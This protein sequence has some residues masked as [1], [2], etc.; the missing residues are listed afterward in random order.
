MNTKQV[1]NIGESSV[2][3]EFVYHNVPVYL[4]FGDNDVCDLIAD[5]GGKLQR[6]QV[7]TTSKIVNNRIQ[8]K[9]NSRRYD[10]DH[11][12]ST[13]EVDYF[14]LFC[15]ENRKTYLVKN[16]EELNCRAI[17]LTLNSSENNQRKNA[18]IS[19]DYEIKNV[20]FNL[21]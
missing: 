7:K 1:G 12:Y 3:S 9:L 10:H 16:T 19:D 8:F 15:V 17:T 4:P 13:S 21:P 20:L 6:I 14:A 5:F 2:I 11:S 18:N